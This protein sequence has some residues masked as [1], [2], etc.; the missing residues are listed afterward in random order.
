[1]GFRRMIRVI[2][3]RV[4]HAVPTRICVE[5]RICIYLCVTHILVT[6]KKIRAFDTKKTL[7]ELNSNIKGER[8]KQCD[9]LEY[10]GCHLVA[11]L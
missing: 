7:T 3:C 5:S 4:Q 6:K 1:M 2:N 9:V 8:I 11:K 10:L